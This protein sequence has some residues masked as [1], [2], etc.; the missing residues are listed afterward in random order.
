MVIIK[1]IKDLFLHYDFSNNNYSFISILEALFWPAM[2]SC[3]EA[4]GC[5]VD[6]IAK[7]FHDTI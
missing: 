5:G 7:T 4:T 3:N 1:K 2:N 6:G